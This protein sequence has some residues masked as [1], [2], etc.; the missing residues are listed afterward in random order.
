[1]LDTHKFPYFKPHSGIQSRVMKSGSDRAWLKDN[2]SNVVIRKL[3]ENVDNSDLYDY[4]SKIGNVVCCKVSKTMEKNDVSNR[5]SI[6]RP[7]S[8]R[9]LKALAGSAPMP[10]LGSLGAG[11]LTPGALDFTGLQD[12]E[13]LC[14]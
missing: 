1:M 12:P 7:S 6:L 10:Q 2:S 8:A 3:D 5:L 14:R 11:N 9:T 13:R 4:F